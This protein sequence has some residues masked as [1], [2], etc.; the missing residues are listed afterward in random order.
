MY[1]FLVLWQTLGQRKQWV[2][3]MLNLIITSKDLASTYRRL[4]FWEEGV[5]SVGFFPD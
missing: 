5:T 3:V 2:K 1:L 4:V